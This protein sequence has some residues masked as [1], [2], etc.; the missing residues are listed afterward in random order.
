M[1]DAGKL[2]PA[3]QHAETVRA[4]FCARTSLPAIPANMMGQS[5]R[6]NGYAVSCSGGL[7]RRIM[8]E[9]TFL[10]WRRSHQGADPSPYWGT[11]A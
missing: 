4:C 3:P 8:H 2:S 9:Y 11:D 1:A 7:T 6:F 10:T 5:V